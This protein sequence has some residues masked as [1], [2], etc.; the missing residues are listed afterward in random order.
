MKSSRLEK[1]K[2]KLENNIINDI[3]NLFRIKKV[4]TDPAIKDIKNHSR[5]KKNRATKNRVI[6]DIRNLFRPKKNK[7][8]KNGVIRDIRSLFEHEEEGNCHKLIRVGSFWSINYIEY[9]S[10]FERNKTPLVEEYLHKIKSYL[11]DIINDLKKSDTWKNQLT[12]EINF[13]SCKD[14]NE[15]REM[16]SKNGNIEIMINDEA[17]E[18]IEAL[19]N[20]PIELVVKELSCFD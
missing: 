11:K 6:G 18:V 12:I 15:E 16:H 3:R 19:W 14:K 10:N 13:F 20:V 2:K 1:D 8:I 5:L 4:V 17:D 7:E 9:E